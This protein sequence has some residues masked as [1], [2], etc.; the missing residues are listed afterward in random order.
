MVLCVAFV[1]E[2]HRSSIHTGCVLERCSSGAE[3]GAL[4]AREGEINDYFEHTLESMRVP[5]F[6]HGRHS[7]AAQQN[8][9]R[10]RG[11]SVEQ[12]HCPIDPARKQ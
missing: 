10:G 6:I 12:I 9:P 2:T 3:L 8:F 11:E 7:K 4:K 1:H 5:S